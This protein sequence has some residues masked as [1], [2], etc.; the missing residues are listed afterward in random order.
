MIDPAGFEDLDTAGV[1]AAV[2]S[3]RATADRAEAELLALVVRLV[4]LHP[5]SVELLEG[6]VEGSEML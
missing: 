1:F 6:L 3:R 2:R 5:A 4:D